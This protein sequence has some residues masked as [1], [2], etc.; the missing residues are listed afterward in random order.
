MELYTPEPDYE[1]MLEEKLERVS[2]EAWDAHWE[3]EVF[4]D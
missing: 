2:E 4:H 3:R 1:T